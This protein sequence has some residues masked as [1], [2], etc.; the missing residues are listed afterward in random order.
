M[1][2]WALTRAS[3]E[4]E[5]TEHRSTLGAQVSVHCGREC[6]LDLAVGDDGTGRPMTARSLL[7]VYCT[8]K[9]LLAS[10]VGKL[11]DDGSIDLDEPVAARLGDVVLVEGGMTLRHLLTHTAGLA[12][13][14]AV[15]MELIPVA[16][17]RTALEQHRRMPQFTLGVDPAYS[18]HVAW[19]VMGWTVEQC[20]G[21]PLGDTLRAWIAT[22][23]LHDTYVGMTP[24]EY[25]EL[26]GRIGV[27]HERRTDGRSIAMILERS[28]RWCTEVNPSHG[29]YTSAHDLSAFYAALLAQRNGADLPGLPSAATLTA[30][31]TTQR[32]AAFDPVL[33]RV[34]P[35][36][37]GFMTSLSEHAFGEM[38][39]ASSFGHSGY[40]GASFAMADPEHD[41]TIAATYNGVIAYDEAFQRRTELIRAIYRDVGA[42]SG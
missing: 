37:L 17:R 2:D 13:P 1:T 8:I 32:E 7:R 11:V 29:G 10:Y 4:R 22:L 12:R 41:L 31:T 6:V 38:P 24:D 21:A 19:Q 34:C 5:L 30:F 25:R 20:T 16:V 18:E 9:P 26:L 23:G 3:V 14:M 36:G 40:V 33:D 27:S 35:Y 42:A 15:E 28:E 39:S